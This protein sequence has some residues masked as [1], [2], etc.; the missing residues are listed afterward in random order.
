MTGLR[1]EDRLL[2][3]L[4]SWMGDLVMAEPVVDALHQALVEGRL[5]GLS[6]VAPTRFRELFLGELPGARWLAPEDDWRGHEIG[7]FLDG[8]LRSVL[9][10]LRSGIR[11]RVGWTDGGR[12]LLLTDG[13]RPALE[14][15]GTPLD[16]GMHGGGRRRLPRPFGASA[17]ELCACLEVLAVARPPR[18]TPTTE[19]RAAVEARLKDL[20]L[21]AGEPYLVLDG[22]ARPGS[23][24][25][26][27]AGLWASALEQ[28]PAG[29]PPVVV[30]AAPGE[31]AL[32]RELAELSGAAL[33][34]APPPTLPELLAVIAGARLFL[35]P[36]S[37]PRHLATAT[38]RRQ[39]ILH[40]PTDPRHTADHTGRTLSVRR[41]VDCG[42]CHLERCPLPAPRTVRC[43][44]TLDPARIAGAVRAA[45]EGEA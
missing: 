43:F 8:S 33:F 32:A 18:L 27:P 19:A 28:L 31:G 42:P 23:A 15:G 21:A 4:P 3:R 29:L 45:L 17:A 20:G 13:L 12:G 37:G 16:L 22:S 38:G 36:D 30:L 25:A 40:G 41:R 2:V 39:V 26:A 34:D 35:G 24:K 11:R 10:A 1:P 9:R 5:A 14:R 7:L 44:T 6:L